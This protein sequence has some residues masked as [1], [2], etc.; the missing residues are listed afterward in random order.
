VAAPPW[1]LVQQM[2]SYDCPEPDAESVTARLA[3][4]VLLPSRSLWS[5]DYQLRRGV[6]PSN[7]AA[8]GVYC[9]LAVAVT[10]L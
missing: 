8:S 6:T 1:F 9:L 3:A 10:A 2:V 5:V 7:Q 4:P